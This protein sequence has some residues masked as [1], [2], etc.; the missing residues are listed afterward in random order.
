MS[1]STQTQPAWT[2]L[3]PLSQPAVLTQSVTG[4]STGSLRRWR[5]RVLR[6]PTLA[7]VDAANPPRGPWRRM[8]AQSVEADIRTEILPDADSDGVPDASD[9]CVAIANPSQIDTDHDLQG[10]ACDADDDG[11]DL[12]DVFETGGGIYVSPGNTGSNPLDSDSDDDGF[13]DG[14]EVTGHANPNDAAS[15][16]LFTDFDQL[17]GAAA[18]TCGVLTNGEL[19]CFGGG[20]PLGSIPT[21]TFRSVTA[22]TLPSYACALRTSGAV[23]CWG[24]GPTTPPSPSYLQI[25]GGSNFVCGLLPSLA[26]QCWGGNASG[27]ASPP[28]GLYSEVSAGQIHACAL[29]L[30]GTA[31]CWGA[32]TSGQAAAPDGHTFVEIAA[33][34]SHTC[35]LHADGSVLCW[36]SNTSG[37]TTVA[38]GVYTQISAGLSHT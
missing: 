36:G 13:N 12:L 23:T 18:F 33:G 5:A 20:L 15:Q 38:P 2:T 31:R 32:N 30:D 3:T 37:Q 11:D 6:A 9:N 10:D 24:G 25:S 4:L 34:S 35:G 16:P 28:P 8:R 17:D 27:Q 21:G 1:C 29:A 22:G 26:L 7:I 19:A 14:F